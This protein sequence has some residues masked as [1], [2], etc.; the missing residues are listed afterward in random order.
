MQKIIPVDPE[1][2]L[3]GYKVFCSGAQNVP[4]ACTLNFAD[5][6][7]NNNKFYIIQILVNNSASHSSSK[8]ALF[9]RYGRN[10]EKGTPTTKFFT[11]HQALTQFLKIYQNKTG[12]KWGELFES[13][14]GKYTKLELVDEVLSDSSEELSNTVPIQKDKVL[15]LVALLSDKQLHIN[16][17]KSFDIKMPLGK[18]SDELIEKA[19]KVLVYISTILSTI[20]SGEWE[21]SKDALELSDGLVKGIFV[22]KSNIFWTLIP[23]AS[24]RNK[25]PPL[26]DN[27][28]QINK[29]FQLLDDM[30]NSSIA[31]KILDNSSDIKNVYDRMKIKITDVTDVDERKTIETFITSTHAPTHTYGIQIL[32]VFRVERTNL[33]NKRTIFD[34]LFNHRLLVHGSRMSN[35]MSILSTGLRVPL[36]SQVANGSI[37][38]PGIYFADVSSKSLNYCQTS[39][40]N[41]IGFLLLCEVALGEDQEECETVV[42]S[43]N[44]KL[45]AEYTSRWGV[46]KSTL[47]G[48][49][50]YNTSDDHLKNVKI[51]KG[52]IKARQG[53]SHNSSFLYNEYVIFNPDQYRMKYLVKI[54]QK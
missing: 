47:S 4:C 30:K 33:S 15:E 19:R 31:Y 41:G 51:P 17:I 9:T 14:P 29:C 24:G 20:S 36:A 40:T 35:F 46:G 2:T 54:V 10:G 7:C 18:I 25:S 27:T 5:I 39:D 49:P 16:S 1:F 13:K 42:D 21:K 48:Y 32:D 53:L 28:E 22:Q 6:Q 45:K 23:F 8:Y 26:I 3:S 52:P 37:L 34:D 38:G 12:N 50:T 44:Q 43:D 11:E